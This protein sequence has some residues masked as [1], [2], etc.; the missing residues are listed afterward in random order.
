[1]PD[2]SGSDGFAIEEAEVIYWGLCPNCATTSTALESSRS[3]P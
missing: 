3:Q 1:M 2:A